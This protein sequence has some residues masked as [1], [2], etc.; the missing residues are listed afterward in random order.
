MS[1]K[2]IKSL[3]LWLPAYLLSDISAIVNQFVIAT[4]AL[5][6]SASPI[7]LGILLAVRMVGSVAGGFLSP[8]M[9]RRWGFGPMIITSDLGG[10]LTML[11]LALAPV[12]WDLNILPIA[13]FFAGFFH[14]TF[15]VSLMAK[16]PDFLG[17]DQR[18]RLNAIFASIE[19]IAVIVGGIAAASV[20]T[21]MPVKYIFM[22]DAITFVIAALAFY[23]FGSG[24][25]QKE[26]RDENQPKG[27]QTSNTHS[28]VGLIPKIL[29]TAF[30]IVLMTRF[31]EAFGSAAHNVGFPIISN[32]FGPEN[33][34]YLFGWMMAVWGIGKLVSNLITPKQ[35]ERSETDSNSIL[36]LFYLYLI[37]MFVSFWVVFQSYSLPLLLMMSFSAGYFDAATETAYYSI[38]QTAPHEIKGE[39]IGFSHFLERAGLGLGIVLAG[40]SFAHYGASTTAT[41][42]YGVPVIIVAGFWLHH[43][44]A[45][46]PQKS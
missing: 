2:R 30:A 24:L 4:Y 43:R 3:K 10:A 21:Y 14:G 27:E 41:L 37:F 20:Y 26:A 46:V 8:P 31:I 13:V 15:R 7:Y 19:G 34:A 42:Y 17:E 35:L 9:V 29:V 5:T 33:P 25:I 1:D 22:I 32:S 6:L 38:L 18:H 40:L 16:V 45:S 44:F 36:P 39:L 12:H 28:H 11:A 23:R